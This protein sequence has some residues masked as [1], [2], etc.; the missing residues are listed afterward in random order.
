MPRSR[1]LLQ[2]FPFQ[3]YSSLFSFLR[4]FSTGVASAAAA[5]RTP[6]HSTRIN[7]TVKNGPRSPRE[8]NSSLVSIQLLRHEL[9]KCFPA[10]CDTRSTLQ[11][12][13]KPVR[14]AALFPCHFLLS[15][16]C[17]YAVSRSPKEIKSQFVTTF[18]R[19]IILP[20]RVSLVALPRYL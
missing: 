20:R 17:F 4:V 3:F 9:L 12:R 5:V 16:L 13:T 10:K 6:C 18:T 14:G 19:W 7:W 1:F 2:L 11:T 8:R 15:S